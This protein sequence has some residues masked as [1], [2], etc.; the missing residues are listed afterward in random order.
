MES[1]TKWDRPPGYS[2]R[3]LALLFI[4]L[5]LAVVAVD[6]TVLNVAIPAISFDLGASAASIQWIIDAY[7]LVFAALLLT[8][9]S[10]SDRYGRK[11]WLQIGVVLFGIGSVAAA[12]TNSTGTLIAT[13]AFL[14]M[15][16]AIILPSTLSLVISTFPR[17]ERSMAIGIWAATFGLGIGFGPVVG[18]YVVEH[19]SWN[20][21]FLLQFPIAI[22]A[23]TGGYFYI[24]ESRD[25]HAPKVDLPGVVLSITGLFS[26]IYG[27]IKAGE[28]S[29]TE[30]EVL[31]AFGAA[32]VLLTAFILWELRTPTPMLPM[33]FFRNPSFSGASFAISLTF[34][35]LFGTVLF[36]SQYLQTVQGYT[37]FESGIRMLPIAFSMA[38]V[39]A[40]SA[41]VS[42][43]LGLKV[44][45]GIGI[46]IAAS[47]LYFSSQYYEV[48]SSYGIVAVSMVLIAG[49]LGLAISPAT[50]SIMSA[51]P[52]S[53]SGIGS[54][55][56]DTTREI[57]GAM[58]VAV[59]GTILNNIYIDRVKGLGELLPDMP[60]EA[61]HAVQESIQGAHFIAAS[62]DLPVEVSSTIIRIADDA[63]VSGMT[64]AMFIGSLLMVAASAFVFI[65]LPATVRPPVE[66]TGAIIIEPASAEF[67]E[68]SPAVSGGD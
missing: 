47:G 45:I 54:A 28:L 44:T 11:R 13:R 39:S 53:K 21:I 58:G 41:L 19:Y 67:G 5:S 51:V 3:W 59:L 55:M 1:L 25:E 35:A 61:L 38:I 48:D 2:T 52:A 32:A 16:A 26:L 8:M 65:F 12:L 18:G 50:D 22:I 14:G 49:G 57:G 9:G 29:W 27:V 36:V 7:S 4:N 20:A 34:F 46:L 31:I 17:E 40:L 15:G 62:P 68:S 6:N 66:E 63:F 60:T 24:R 64:E 33:R 10:I 23:L 56:N 42:A 37:P 30:T 43:R